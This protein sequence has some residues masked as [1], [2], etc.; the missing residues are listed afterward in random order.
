MFSKAPASAAGFP[1]L[2]AI[3]RCIVA[4]IG[5]TSLRL[6]EPPKITPVDC[7]SGIAVFRYCWMIQKEVVER[8]VPLSPVTKCTTFHGRQSPPNNSM[9]WA[10]KNMMM[11]CDRSGGIVYTI[12]KVLQYGFVFSCLSLSFFTIH[13][14]LWTD[15]PCN[16]S[17][18][19]DANIATT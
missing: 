14:I 13:C 18:I 11:P 4:H 1:A 3:M 6:E 10:E 8:V 15:L 19:I 5:S 17:Y 12:Y 2:F 9:Q 7:A 16:M